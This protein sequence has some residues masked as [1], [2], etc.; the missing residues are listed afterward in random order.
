M[1]DTLDLN[2][3]F[4]RIGYQ[5]SR[6]PR[7]IGNWFA[8]AH[9]RSHFKNRLIVARA[10]DDGRRITL[11]NDQ[12][13]ARASNGHAEVTTLATPEELLGVLASHFGLHFPKGTRF[14]PAGSPWPS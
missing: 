1:S 7:E 13:K 9:P 10:A 11:L 14:G 4:D 6:V 8:S 12:L 5:G 2:A 3:Y